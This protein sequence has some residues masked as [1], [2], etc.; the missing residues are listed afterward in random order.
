MPEN[1]ITNSRQMKVFD[2][3]GPRL[4]LILWAELL[5]IQSGVSKDRKNLYMFRMTLIIRLQRFEICY[6]G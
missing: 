5:S 6:I 3:A 1:F 2:I 4:K